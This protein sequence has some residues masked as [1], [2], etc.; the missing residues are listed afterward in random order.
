MSSVPLHGR[1]PDGARSHKWMYSRA[2]WH[3][4]GWYFTHVQ[5]HAVEGGGD[6]HGVFPRV[7][8]LEMYLSYLLMNGQGRFESQI[9]E[10]SRGGWLTT[11]VEK[12]RAAV[13]IWNWHA[14]PVEVFPARQ[15]TGDRTDWGARY[16]LGQFQVATAPLLIPRLAEVHAWIGT[17]QQQLSPSSLAPS[18]HLWRQMSVGRRDSQMK[19]QVGD[20]S[21]PPMRLQHLM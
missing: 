11:Q 1:Y 2:Q 13:V 21:L 14:S 16:G 17:F 7:S 15:G 12:F 9:C 8:T 6:G 19:I 5:V 18:P 4:L 3:Q 20:D 10:E